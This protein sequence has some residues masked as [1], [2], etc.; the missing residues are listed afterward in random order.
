MSIV[1]RLVPGSWFTGFFLVA[2][3]DSEY[4]LRQPFRLQ[5]Q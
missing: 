4:V 2:A 3:F 5:C 1:I